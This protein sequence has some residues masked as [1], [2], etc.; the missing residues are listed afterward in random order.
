MNSPREQWSL[1]QTSTL[2]SFL[3]PMKRKS[4]KPPDFQKLWLDSSRL[5]CRRCSITFPMLWESL[6][7]TN[8]KLPPL[9]VYLKGK[10]SHYLAFAHHP[11]FCFS[12]G[13]HPEFPVGHWSPRVTPPPLPVISSVAL[14]RFPSGKGFF[15]SYFPEHIVPI[16]SGFPN[17]LYP[18]ANTP[19]IF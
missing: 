3:A 7:A 11:C 12:A 14:T 10:I 15:R 2:S 17:L 13:H 4:A 9:I 8:T 1:L 19:R 5:H 6:Q 16:F 18:Q